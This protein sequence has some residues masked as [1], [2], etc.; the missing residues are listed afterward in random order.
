MKLIE[1]PVQEF[2]ETL[3]SA[4]PAP[5][6]GSAAALAAAVGAALTEMVAN[7]T[8]GKEKFKE[9]ET[10][11]QEILAAGQE[12]KQEFLVLIDRDTAA[13]TKVTA[14]LSLPKTTEEEKKIRQEAMQQA[15]KFA[16]EVPFTLMEKSLEALKLTARALNNTNPHALSDLGVAAHCLLAAMHGGW[17]NVL[18]NLG[19]IKDEGFA[20]Q[21]RQ[22]GKGL[23]A[24]GIRLA[25]KLQAEIENAL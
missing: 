20:G 23:L 19:G 10:L 6:G 16:T 24:E 21:Y 4:S 22:Q 15:L 5:G 3:A 17:L 11:V 14:A 18:I 7:L 12:L 1:Y 2:I 9:K 13:F 8:T 25:G